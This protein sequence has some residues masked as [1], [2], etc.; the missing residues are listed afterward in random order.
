MHA[1]VGTWRLVEWIV[2]LDGRPGARPFGGNATGLLTYTGDGRMWA[3][4]MRTDRPRLGST[5]LAGASAEAR[6][7]AAAGY[8]SYAGTYEVEGDVVHHHVE[9]S[10]FPDW[11]GGVQERHIGWQDGDLVLASA[12]TITEDGITAANRLRWKRITGGPA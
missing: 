9:V 12:G 4:L 5:T 3:A 10:L 2:T 1:L 11:I 8:L 6:A 7:F